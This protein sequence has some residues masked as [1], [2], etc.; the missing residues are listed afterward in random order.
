M[1]FGWRPRKRKSPRSSTAPASLRTPVEKPFD[2]TPKPADPRRDAD[3]VTN[4]MRIAGAWSWR[5]LAVA[6]AAAVV[7][8]LVI[9]L[10]LIVIPLFVAVIIAALLVPF[11]SF[12]QRHRWPKWLAIAVSE[13]GMIAIVSGLL[14]LVVTQVYQG[15][16]DL[17]AKTVESYA[18]LKEWLLTSPLHLT[19]AQ[20]TAYAQQALSAVQQDTS[21]IV[22]GALSVGS[23]IGHLLTGL[24]LVLFSTLFILIDGR[25]IWAWVVRLFPRAARRAVDG[26]GKAGWTTLSNFVRVQIL[27]AFVDAV[28]ISLGAAL[29]GVPLAIPIGVLVFLGSFVP[30]IGAV[31]TGALAVFIALVYNGPLI[32]LFMLLVVLAVQQIEGHIL[33]PLVMGTAVK[34]HPLAVV[35]AV[36]GG[37]IVAGIAGAFFAV[38]FV[39]SLNVMIKYV[40]GGAWRTPAPAVQDPTLAP[41]DGTRAD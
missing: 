25:G 23:T 17:S 11:S 1:R 41:G 13:L 32:A 10:R 39:A 40:A 22:S 31:V 36:A 15:Y 24:L 33:Q 14:F 6:A 3:F 29:L 21:A 30:V 26:A 20:I 19:D 27:V 18:D 8:F 37:S 16:D 34:V 35:L 28:G 9:Q 7:I 4:G 5:I 2:A 38:P 12:L